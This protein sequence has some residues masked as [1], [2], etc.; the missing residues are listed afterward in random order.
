M[1][2]TTRKGALFAILVQDLPCLSGLQPQQ[3]LLM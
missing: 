1:K 3:K 2:L